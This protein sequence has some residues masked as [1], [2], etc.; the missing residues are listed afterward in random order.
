[1][2]GFTPATDTQHSSAQPFS[3]PLKF[4]QD[5]WSDLLHGA[6]AARLLRTFRMTSA[7][8]DSSRRW[9][10]ELSWRHT[11]RNLSASSFAQTK[12]ARFSSQKRRHTPS[13]LVK[14]TRTSSRRYWG[15]RQRKGLPG[16]SLRLRHPGKGDA[17]Q[18]RAQKWS[19]AHADNHAQGSQSL[20]RVAAGCYNLVRKVRSAPCS[21]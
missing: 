14:Y 12:R 17:R 16:L 11:S 1:M 3:V 10:S 8:S 4:P 6:R 15:S 7:F 2:R 5:G 18:Q 13:T 9:S 19:V 20:W 21:L